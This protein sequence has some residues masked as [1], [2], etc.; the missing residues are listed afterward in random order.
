MDFEARIF[1]PRLGWRRATRSV[2]FNGPF[3]GLSEMSSL[4]GR[5][6]RAEAMISTYFVV[7]QVLSEKLRINSRDSEYVQIHIRHEHSLKIF[8]NL[9][10]RK[11]SVTY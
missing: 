3:P 6:H 9:L 4:S 11:E 7:S 5:V 1:A 8:V 10:Y 2:L